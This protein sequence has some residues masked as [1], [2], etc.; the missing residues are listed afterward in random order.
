VKFF[1]QPRPFPAL[2]AAAL[3]FLS[4]QGGPPPESVERDGQR[5]GVTEGAFRGR[6]WNYYERGR[7]FADGDFWKRAE[8]DFRE[9]LRGRGEDQLR[10]RTYGMHFVD[11]FPHRELGIS[12]FFQDRFAE[13]IRELEDSYGSQPTARAAFY[14]DR[15]RR[16]FLQS[17]GGDRGPPEIRIDRPEDGFLTAD[18][19][20]SLSGRI[21]DDT[22][23][24]ALRINDAPYRIDLSA[25]EI[26]FETEVDLLPGDNTIFLEAED[27]LGAAYRTEIS[28]YSDRGGP[29]LNIDGLTP[30]SGG[31]TGLELTGYA[32]DPSGVAAVTVDGRELA[33]DAAP[34]VAIRHPITPAADRDFVEVVA[35]DQ[36]GN[37]TEARFSL[38]DSMLSR[39]EGDPGQWTARLSPWDPASFTHRFP[40]ALADRFTDPFTERFNDRG[41]DRVTGRFNGRF[42][43]LA[44]ARAGFPFLSPNSILLASN[45]RGGGITP[46]VLKQRI[47]RYRSVS[48]D[49]AFII[50]INDYVQWPRLQ[51][52][53]NDVEVLRDVLIGRYGYTDERILMLTDGQATLSGIVNGLEQVI[54]AMQ[55]G[56]NL[57]IYFAGH[58]VLKPI[59]DEGYWIPVDGDLGDSTTWLMNS[60][61]RKV[62]TSPYVIAKNIAVVA[63][64]C[65]SGTLTRSGPSS[66]DVLSAT[67]GRAVLDNAFKKSR[68]IF[69]SGGTEPVA[70][71]GA[72]GHSLFAYHFLKA[73]KTNPE[74]VVDL[75]KLFYADVFPAVVKTGNQRPTSTKL[76]EFD[77]GGQ[78]IFVLAEG[79]AVAAAEEPVAPSPQRQIELAPPPAPVDPDPPVLTLKGWSEPRTVYLERI[80]I[81]GEVEDATGVQTLTVNDQPVLL[82]PGRHVFFH[83]LVDLEIGENRVMVRCADPGGQTTE[84]E[85]VIHRKQPSVFDTGSRM[86]L[87]VH[88]FTVE[89]GN[90]PGVADSFLKHLNRSGRFHVKAWRNRER[91]ATRGLPPSLEAE[92][93]AAAE[94]ARE[95]GAEFVLL[96]KVIA[97]GDS[98]E[99]WSYVVEAE[100]L[101]VLTE[102]DVFAEG[103]ERERVDLLCRG[104]V[105]KLEDALPMLE[106]KVVSVKRNEVIVNLG[107]NHRLKRGMHLIFFEE[108]EPLLDPDTGEPLGAD[109]F[110]F[111]SGRLARLRD[112]LSYA[113]PLSDAEMEAV[114]TGLRVVT[115]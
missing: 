70:D 88:P 84:R 108:G 2:W 40:D 78:F 87:F 76:K 41:T 72:D 68:E 16:E 109:V 59:F 33:L 69:T 79:A 23:V 21:L 4:C 38:A 53:V 25:P 28:V 94:M 105:N 39:K 11:Y 5:Y 17:Q 103:A 14:L 86:S 106:G 64:S 100:Q 63:D 102:Q 95:R 97:R 42:N 111:G 13:A 115:K 60:T 18:S 12:L 44:R 15:A 114:R 35:V 61:V 75:E 104:L 54:A 24:A 9:A 99:I 48:R 52:A 43:D 71:G 51:T 91:E 65:Y 30:A 27:L 57:L 83:H 7:S 3:L 55:E 62:L 37:R 10:A 67:R 74:R 110:E 32:T 36:V 50:G 82:H 113:E 26:A 85:I 47:R 58:G 19:T 81:E 29:I 92:I 93:D 89:G 49:F 73:L 112:R 101:D 6:W 8:A 90:R 20:L 34:D 56:D 31:G 45:L 77:E 22:F 107:Q 80:F 46:M 96:G 66:G 1:G 98:T